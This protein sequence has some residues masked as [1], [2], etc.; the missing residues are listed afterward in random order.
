MFITSYIQVRRII[1]DFSV[2]ISVVIWSL[3]NY[4]AHVQDLPTLEVPNLLQEGFYANND[5][6]R[7]S[8]FISP[9]GN[10]LPNWAPVAAL[11]PSLLATILI[12]MDQQITALIINRKDH[13]LKVRDAERKDGWTD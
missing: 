5:S 8:L 1:S 13:K 2:L 7:S 12:F 6:V 4:F 3:V 10:G 11:I 9:L